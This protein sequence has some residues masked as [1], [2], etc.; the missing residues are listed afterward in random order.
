[1]AGNFLHQMDEAVTCEMFFSMNGLLQ[2]IQM[3]SHGFYIQCGKG[4]LHVSKKLI[5]SFTTKKMILLLDL[6]PYIDSTRSFHKSFFHSQ[7][8]CLIGSVQFSH[9]CDGDPFSQ[10][11][12]HSV[13]R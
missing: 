2:K 4:F 10:R 3:L 11:Q 12:L 1:M 9:F 6:I 13:K 8:C 5:D 7:E